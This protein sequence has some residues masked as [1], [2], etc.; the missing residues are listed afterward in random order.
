M[1]RIHPEEDVNVVVVGGG[2]NAYWRIMAANHRKTV[3]ID[4]WK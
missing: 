2:T 4:D 1:I 3:S